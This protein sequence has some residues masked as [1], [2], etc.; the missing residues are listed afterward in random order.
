MSDG[1]IRMSEVEN[2]AAIASGTAIAVLAP[3][4]DG[5]IELLIEFDTSAAFGYIVT[6][7]GGSPMALSLLNL[8]GA[9]VANAPY[10]FTIVVKAGS[11]YDFRH[12]L[13]TNVSVKQFLPDLVTRRT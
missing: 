1:F 13:G 11:T 12:T 6:P 10:T 8:G 2:G 5:K 4:K 7:F 3:T 9:L